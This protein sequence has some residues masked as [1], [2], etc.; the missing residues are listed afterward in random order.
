M[1]VANEHDQ[2]H[3]RAGPILHRNGNFYGILLRKM[4]DP[5]YCVSLCEMASSSYVTSDILNLQ[6]SFGG[7]KNRSRIDNGVAAGIPDAMLR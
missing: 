7:N 2:T 1:T 5:S 4:L 3:C 6:E